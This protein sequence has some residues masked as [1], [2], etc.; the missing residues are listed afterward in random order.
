MKL[1]LSNLSEKYKSI[2]PNTKMHVFAKTTRI[3]LCISFL[4]LLPELKKELSELF[5]YSCLV[6]TGIKEVIYEICRKY[7]N[8]F[9]AMGKE[10]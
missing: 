2:F 5:K 9:L 7:E 6:F 1:Q 3:Y 10:L 8:C 4:H